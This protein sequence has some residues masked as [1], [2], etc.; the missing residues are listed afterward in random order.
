MDNVLEFLG[1][2]CAL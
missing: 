2:T 1:L